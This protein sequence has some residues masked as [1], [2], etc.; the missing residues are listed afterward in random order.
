MIEDAIV[1]TKNNKSKLN[2]IEQL[3]VVYNYQ[4]E[5]YSAVFVAFEKKDGSWALKFDPVEVGI[6]KNGFANPLTKKEGDGKSPTGIF[7]LGKLFSYEKQLNTL[8]ENQQTTADDKWIDDPDSV[9]YNTY[10]KGTTSAKS[11]ENLLLKNDAY[12]YCMVV[13]YNTNPVIKGNG[14]AIFFHLGVKKPYFTAG[15]VAIDE[16]NMKSIVNWLD[17]KMNP[18]IIMGNLNVLKNGL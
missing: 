3:L 10:V 16:G 12:K 2:N 7:R 18:S 9:D 15:C 5:S 1:I 6:G 11:Y 13:E 8:L 17:P 4:P 14:S